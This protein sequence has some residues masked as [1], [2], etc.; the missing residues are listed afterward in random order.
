VSNTVIQTLKNG[1][2]L[3]EREIELKDAAGKT[4]LTKDK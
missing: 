2:F 3:V 4:I 1:P